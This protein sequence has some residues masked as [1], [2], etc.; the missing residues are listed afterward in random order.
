MPT[1]RE[2]LLILILFL[3]PG[4]I[5]DTLLGRSY[6]RQ[7]REATE[8]VLSI[9]VWSL[10]NYVL[11]LVLVPRATLPAPTGN[12]AGYIE[13]HRARAGAV[14]AGVLLIAPAVEAIVVARVMRAGRVQAVLRR[15]LG[16]P[17][18]SAPK[19]WDDVFARG[20]DKGYLVLATLTDGSK[21]GGLWGEGS[22][23]SSFPAEEDLYLEA[24]Y[25]LGDDNNFGEVIPLSAGVLLKRT[26]IRSLELFTLEQEE[27][28]G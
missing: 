12:Y 23:A 9:V 18:Q 17:V 11:F 14:A 6:P 16:F 26:D 15:L 3:I 28:D 4:Y 7:K 2:A 19:A 27:A 5:A 24:T 25:R 1:T 13:A 21:I 8:T 20:Q 10:F 22:F